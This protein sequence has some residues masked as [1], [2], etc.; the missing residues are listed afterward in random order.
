MRIVKASALALLLG[1]PLW[2]AKP[3][4]VQW[5]AFNAGLKG[6]AEAHKYVFVDVYTDWCTYCK[7]LDAT[8]LRNESVVSELEQNFV[9]VKL[10]AES[11]KDVTWQGKR[12]SGRDLAATWGVE[13]F[14]TL[15]F[16][17]PKGEMIG[18][19]A[20]FADDDLMVKLL[21]YISSGARERK[22]SF[23]EFL[24]SSKVKS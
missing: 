15:I 9:S 22:V 8:T 2:A 11:D 18:V 1:F 21:T 14:P 6:A 5:K 10:N 20:S 17:N 4:E 23:D 12:M 19:F 13:G 3:T 16:L 7:K 24:K